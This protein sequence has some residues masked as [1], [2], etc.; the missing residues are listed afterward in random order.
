MTN[1]TRKINSLS[2]YVIRLEKHRQ[3]FEEVAI[4][5]F[6]FPIF[7]DVLYKKMVIAKIKEFCP[8]HSAENIL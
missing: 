3:Q 7:G 1:V 6:H 4:G 8:C 2:G 5:A